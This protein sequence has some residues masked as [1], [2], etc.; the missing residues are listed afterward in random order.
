MESIILTNRQNH[1]VTQ[2][3]AHWNVFF[4]GLTVETEIE[5]GQN[6]AAVRRKKHTNFAAKALFHAV[7]TPLN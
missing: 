3:G 4:G 2:T 6:S 1:A 5:A 7:F